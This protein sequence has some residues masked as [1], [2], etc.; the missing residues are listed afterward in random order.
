MQTPIKR[1]SNIWEQILASG[2]NKQDIIHQ[3][4]PG[5]ATFVP[6]NTI[7]QNYWQYLSTAGELPGDGEQPLAAWAAAAKE[8]A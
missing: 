3:K 7:T 2:R 6:I 1:F 8:N 5:A 4:W